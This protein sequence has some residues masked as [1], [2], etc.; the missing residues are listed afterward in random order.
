[1]VNPRSSR[2]TSVARRLLALC[3]CL[4]ASALP[5]ACGE[6]AS[7]A[8]R[9]EPAAESTTR[10][11]EGAPP[12]PVGPSIIVITI[13]TLRRDHLSLYGYE[14]ATSPSLAALAAESIVFERAV[15]TSP[16]T[17]PSTASLFSG[18]HPSEHGAHGERKVRTDVPLLASVLAELGYQT[19]A[20]SANPY[21]SG[22]YGLDR[23][24]ALFDFQG[25]DAARD[26][27]DIRALVDRARFWLDLREPGPFFLYLHVMNVHGPYRAPPEYRERFLDGPFEEFPFQNPLWEA[28]A[29]ERRFERRAEVKAEHLRDLSARYDGAIAYTDTVLGALIQDLRTR[30]VLDQS[31][32]LITAD[33]GEELFDHGSFGHRRSLHRELLDI[34]LL[35]RL[36][37]GREG[38]LRISEPVSLIDVPATLLELA[39]QEHA[40][41][42]GRFGRGV[43]LAPLLEP[44]RAP[45]PARAM[46]AELMQ[47][48]GM[49]SMLEEWPYRM[50]HMAGEEQARLYR[51]DRDAREAHDLAGE[52]PAVLERLSEIARRMQPDASEIATGEVVPREGELQKQLEALGYVEEQP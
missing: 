33:H 37:G 31:V 3:A 40:L 38:G 28:I 6:R 30:G 11:E 1:V 5:A 4:A 10:N 14:R 20:F 52:E 27:V 43:S 44:G 32:L 48:G 35:L 2:R 45:E 29:Q 50:I 16:W 34:P 18:L 41:D 17:K 49:S 47:Q 24:F 21:A 19:A 8:P 23:G 39:G 13:D 22:I 42:E 9:A 46:R 26:Y 15:S 12:K 7:E 51:L 36:P 25:G